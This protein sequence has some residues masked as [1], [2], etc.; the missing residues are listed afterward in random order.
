MN[1]MDPRTTGRVCKQWRSERSLGKRRL[2][3]RMSQEPAQASVWLTSIITL[4]FTPHRPL[5]SLLQWASRARQIEEK[6][7]RCEM[8]I[9][10][11][12]DVIH[13]LACA[14]SWDMRCDNRLLPNDLSDLHCLQI[15]PLVLGSMRFI[16]VDRLV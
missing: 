8:N 7:V 3:Q 10:V 15:L 16:P 5:I 13:T 12:M 9:T 11:M 14:G 4:L 6:G 1:R 2:S